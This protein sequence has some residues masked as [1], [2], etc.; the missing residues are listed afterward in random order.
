MDFPSFG[1]RFC[2]WKNRQA[3]QS[4][5]ATAATMMPRNALL[6]IVLSGQPIMHR[7]PVTVKQ[8]VVPGRT[9]PGTGF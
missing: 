6:D 2:N 5:R 4:S 9:V 3:Q 1:D 8:I 7:Q